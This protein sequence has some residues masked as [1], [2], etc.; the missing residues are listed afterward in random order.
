MG[1]SVIRVGW[2]SEGCERLWDVCTACTADGNIVTLAKDGEN[3]L[4]GAIHAKDADPV[5][6]V[7]VQEAPVELRLGLHARDGRMVALARREDGSL[8]CRWFAPDELL[9]WNW[10]GLDGQT[11]YSVLLVERATGGLE[12]FLIDEN[13]VLH[14]RWTN[15]DHVWAEH[16]DSLESEPCTAVCVVNNREGFPQAYVRL[17]DGRIAVRR[18]LNNGTWNTWLPLGGSFVQGPWGSADAEGWAHVFAVDEH[19]FLW[20]CRQIEI[21]RY[22]EWECAGDAMALARSAN[23][24]V[25]LKRGKE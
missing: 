21:D 20:K 4:V 22:G 15:R 8:L 9:P 1:K 5:F 7:L 6:T 14:H 2:S 17:T 13:G 12:A 16:W 25:T 18:H 24:C 3:R 19:G 11:A 10:D 23:G